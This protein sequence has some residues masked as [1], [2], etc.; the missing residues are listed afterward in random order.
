MITADRL[1]DDVSGGEVAELAAVNS[2]IAIESQSPKPGVGK[3]DS[4]V[5]VGAT[6]EVHDHDHVV[7]VTTGF[8]AAKGDDLS[9]L[10]EMKQIDNLTAEASAAVAGVQSQVDQIG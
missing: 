1:S 6:P 3:A 4:V 7:T 8:A 5:V 9:G 2:G 10:V